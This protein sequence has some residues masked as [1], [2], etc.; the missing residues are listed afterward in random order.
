MTHF[1]MP[2]GRIFASCVLPGGML[3]ANAS[4][5][6]G[7]PGLGRHVPQRLC[8]KRGDTLVV[9]GDAGQGL[10]LLSNCGCMVLHWLTRLLFRLYQCRPTPALRGRGI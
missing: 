6:G 5:H 7:E 3:A 9:R 8:R 10:V 1:G 4:S 2:I